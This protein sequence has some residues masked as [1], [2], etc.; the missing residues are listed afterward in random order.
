MTNAIAEYLPDEQSGKPSSLPSLV[1][2]L[3]GFLTF[4]SMALSLISP[5][6]YIRSF[7]RFIFHHFKKCSSSVLKRG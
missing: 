6:V 7:I 5:A 2:N 1:H 3:F 4:R